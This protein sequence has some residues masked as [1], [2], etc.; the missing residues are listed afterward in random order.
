MTS[1]GMEVVQTHPGECS[2][3]HSI[4]LDYPRSSSTKL[5]NFISLVN[6]NNKTKYHMGYL[7]H[8]SKFLNY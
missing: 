8:I 3:I 1:S 4:A 2:S 5:S 6:V 7:D